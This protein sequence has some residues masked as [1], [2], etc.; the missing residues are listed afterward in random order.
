M[1]YVATHLERKTVGELSCEGN[2]RYRAIDIDC[3]N[4]D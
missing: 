3:N 1:D 2:S 4:A